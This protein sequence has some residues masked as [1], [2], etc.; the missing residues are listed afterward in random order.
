MLYRY[1]FGYKIASFKMANVEVSDGRVLRMHEVLLAI[2]VG[3][4]EVQGK[5]CSVGRC[6]SLVH[7]APPAVLNMNTLS[8]TAI[9]CGIWWHLNGLDV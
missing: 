1:Y 5:Q 6:I 9:S 2:K 3:P 8:G 4:V 7:G